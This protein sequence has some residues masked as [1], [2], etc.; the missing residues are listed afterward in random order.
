MDLTHF[1]PWFIS[2]FTSIYYILESI[3]YIYRIMSDLEES[4]DFGAFWKYIWRYLEKASEL[5]IE[6][7]HRSILKKNN[8][9]MSRFEDE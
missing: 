7:D 1:Y 2:V 6:H 8:R 3:K 9:S 4:D 5:T